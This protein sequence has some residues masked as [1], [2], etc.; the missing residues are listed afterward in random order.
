MCQFK[1]IIDY[2]TKP[3]YLSPTTDYYYLS[4]MSLLKEDY[5]VS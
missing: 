5:A 4:M 1:T 3:V 2:T